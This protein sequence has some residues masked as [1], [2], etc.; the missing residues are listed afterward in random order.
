MLIIASR[1]WPGILVILSCEP[2]HLLPV[3]FASHSEM[4]RFSL[5]SRLRFSA[6]SAVK[7]FAK[8]SNRRDNRAFLCELAFVSRRT[9]RSKS[10][11]KLLPA[12]IT[13]HFSAISPSLL[14]ELCG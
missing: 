9:P 3:G 1:M 14:G 6:N 7:V 10:F 8:A 4:L 5:R 12:E 11:Q 2:S 13:E